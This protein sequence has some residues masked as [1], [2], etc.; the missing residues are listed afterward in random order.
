[1][2][3]QLVIFELGK[4]Y[5]GIDIAIVEGIIKMQEITRMPKCPDFVEGLINLRGS[6]LPVIDLQKRFGIPVQEYNHATRIV[7]VNLGDLKI[8]MIVTAVSEVLTIDDS[9]IEPAPPIVTT[10]NSN[11]ISGIARVDSR[12]II[13]LDMNQVLNCQ[14]KTQA[15]ALEA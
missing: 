2:E 13:L 12:L 3:K 15:M 5:F 14:E 8:G 10:V 7:N 1:M 6:V 11:F 4:E 9:V